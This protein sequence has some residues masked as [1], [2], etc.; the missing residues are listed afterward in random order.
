MPEL[1]AF[2]DQGSSVMTSLSWADGLAV[3]PAHTVCRAG[4]NVMFMP[5]SGLY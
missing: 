2:S 4:D 3:I 5:F 1:Q